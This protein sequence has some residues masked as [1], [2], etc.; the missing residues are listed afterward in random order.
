M[1][2]DGERKYSAKTIK[3]KAHRCKVLSLKTGNNFGTILI[4]GIL[5]MTFCGLAAGCSLPSATKYQINASETISQDQ[6]MQTLIAEVQL[7]YTPTI[8]PSL[9]PAPTLTIANKLEPPTMIPSI[10]LSPTL[11]GPQTYVVQEGDNCWKIANDRFN[12]PMDAFLAING[13]TMQ[14]CVIN[15][16]QELLIPGEDYQIPTE[17]PVP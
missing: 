9:T 13:F 7:S 12:I 15:V 11:S 2:I 4:P 17:T 8:A 16:G 3:D 1:K 14:T 6:L 5:F 10:N